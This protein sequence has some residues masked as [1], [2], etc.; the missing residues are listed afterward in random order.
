MAKGEAA[1][2]GVELVGRHP[3][4]GEDPVHL[5]NA[6]SVELL[7]E[8]RERRVDKDELA[9]RLLKSRA[10]GLERRG[11]PVKEYGAPG[12]DALQQRR[13]VAGAAAGQIHEHAV[14][15]TA[16]KGGEWRVQRLADRVHE[17]RLVGKRRHPSFRAS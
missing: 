6:E 5:A 2:A 17:D 4:V 7:I 12:L 16:A 8:R 15:L 11:I 10:G 3:E 9:R 1:S 13:R 14:A